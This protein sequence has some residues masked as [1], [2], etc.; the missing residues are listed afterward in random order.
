[1]K[2]LRKVISLD[3]PSIIWGLFERYDNIPKFYAMGQLFRVLSV[4][5]TISPCM[6]DNV[7]CFRSCM[8]SSKLR[9][10]ALIPVEASLRSLPIVERKR[11]VANNPVAQAITFN[12]MIVTVFNVFLGVQLVGQGSHRGS[13]K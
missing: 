8:D 3:S 5:M 9:Q 4:F 10:V 12:Q 7:A 6:V 11:W 1:M 13:K 2:K